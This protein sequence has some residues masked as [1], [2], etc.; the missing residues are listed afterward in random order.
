[1]KELVILSLNIHSETFSQFINHSS[2]GSWA[3]LV[4]WWINSCNTEGALV[5][6]PRVKAA[7]KNFLPV[8]GTIGFHMLQY[9]HYASKQSSAVSGGLRCSLPLPAPCFH[10]NFLR[11]SVPQEASPLPQ[12][13]QA[14]LTQTQGKSHNLTQIF[15][16]DTITNTAFS[17]TS[18]N[19]HTSWEEC[20]G[21]ISRIRWT[22]FKRQRFL[23][24]KRKRKS[25]KIGYNFRNSLAPP[26]QRK[27]SYHYSR[28]ESNFLL[29]S[30]FQK[31]GGTDW[32][33]PG[34]KMPSLRS[35]SVFHDSFLLF[36]PLHS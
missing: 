26:S 15:A 16:L 19:Y 33:W 34:Y 23:I 25:C 22:A 1:M 12:L 21:G 8:L 35:S 24:R 7:F 11:P 9:K 3:S 2:E 20:I 10:T 5:K 29:E 32:A 31:L 30:N 13:V 14:G 18:T 36:V 17:L 28:Q 6:C 27:L 4:G